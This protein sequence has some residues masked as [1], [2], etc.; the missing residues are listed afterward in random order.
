[1]KNILFIVV[2]TLVSAIAYCQNGV[3]DGKFRTTCTYNKA[4]LKSDNTG[5]MSFEDL[6][7]SYKKETKEYIIKAFIDRGTIYT[8]NL[9]YDRTVKEGTDI[10]YFYKGV[11]SNFMDEPVVVFTRTKLSAYTKNTGFKSL[12]DI[13]DFDKQAISFIFTKTYLVFSIAPIKNAQE[14]HKLKEESEHGTINDPDGY[15]NIRASNSSKSEIVGRILEGEVFTYWKTNDN[16]YKVETPKGVK[17]YVHKSRIK[18][19]DNK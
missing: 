3:V 15:T 13:E 6:K 16:W 2:L 12:D 10:A 5:I 14:A 18:P 11:R 7:I 1:M 9:K 4:Y 19:I 8:F 17:G